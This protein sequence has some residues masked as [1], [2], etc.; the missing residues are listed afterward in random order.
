[1]S[2]V[3]LERSPTED[4]GELRAILQGE[5]CIVTLQTVISPHSMQ[6]TGRGGATLTMK[7][8]RMNNARS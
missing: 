5:S 2:R 1:M 4:A 6:S 7:L 8:D 3:G